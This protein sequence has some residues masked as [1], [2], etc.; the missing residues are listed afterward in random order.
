MTWFILSLLTAFAVASCDAWVKKWF[1]HMSHY[2]MLIYPLLYGFPLTLSSLVFVEIPPLDDIF[3]LSFIV[4]I[5]LT[6]VPLIFYM[7]AIKVSPLSLTV[8]YLAFT[9]VFIVGTGYLF[10]GEEPDRWGVIGILSVCVGSY[11]LNFDI[12]KRSLIDPFLAVFKEKGSWLMLIAAI[13]FSFSAVIGKLA[14]IHSSVMFFQMTFFV[15]VTIIMFVI[16]MVFGL[17]DLKNLTESPIKGSVAGILLFFHILLHGFAIS[18]TKAAYMVSVKRLSI[19]FGVIYG[20][21]IFKEENILIRFTGTLFMFGGA[22]IILLMA[23]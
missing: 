8:P 2:E 5:P 14:I 11:I 3:Y 13:I 20:G 1:S 18:M 6:I 17:I 12:K 21:I 23:D 19:L 9:P 16:F 10:L 4:S 15:V 7:K 22:V